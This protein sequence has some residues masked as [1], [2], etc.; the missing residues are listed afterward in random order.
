MDYTYLI[1]SQANKNIMINDI[2]N[3]NMLLILCYNINTESKYPFIQFMMEKVPFCNNFIKEQFILP[4][5]VYYDLTQSI[6]NL[7]LNKITRSLNIIN[8]DGDKIVESMYKGIVIDKEGR[9]YAMIDITG[10]DLSRLKLTRNMLTWFLLPSEIINKQSVCNVPVDIEV[11]N[12]FTSMPELGILRNKVTNEFF[13]IPDGVYTGDEFKTLE[14]NSVFGNRKRKLYDSCGEYYYFYK[15]FSDAVKDG[16][17]IKD[18]GTK[19]LDLN[20]N[21][22]THNSAERLIVENEYGRY[23]EG[24]IN[25]YALFMEGK[26]YLE[27]GEEFSLTD[28]IIKKDYEEPC[29][30]VCYTGNHKIK[31]DIL[32]KNYENFI[33]LTYHKLNKVLLDDK[34]IEEKKSIYMIE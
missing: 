14:F 16:G 8:C 25:R 34:F 24:G 20:D 5:V 11:V 4:Y 12:L 10:I 31:P 30:I 1:E 23:I 13:I 18:G 7:V 15:D 21:K 29:I 2:N 33:P 6:E 32:V 22:N 27:T 17:W 28:E 9:Q 26:I 19:I 3:M